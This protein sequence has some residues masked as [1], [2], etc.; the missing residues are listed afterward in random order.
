MPIPLKLSV[1]DR[2]SATQDRTQDYAIGE[3]LAL[4]KHCDAFGYHRYWVSEHQNSAS[5]VG[6]APEVLSRGVVDFMR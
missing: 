1:L 6:T 5:I 3:S 4:A 2:S